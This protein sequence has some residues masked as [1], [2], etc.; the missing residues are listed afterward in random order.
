MPII[1]ATVTV[2]EAI[3][4]ARRPS[5]S[6]AAVDRGRHG[7]PEAEAED[8][9]QP[10]TSP[11]PRGRRPG[12]HPDERARCPGRA[13]RA[14]ITRRPSQRRTKPR[15]ERPDRRRAGE[16]AEGDPLDVRAAVEDPVDE[17]GAA[18]DRR[19]EAVA[20]QERDERRRGE[21]RATGT[22]CGSRKGLRVPR[23]RATPARPIATSADGAADEPAGPPGRVARDLLAAG[24]GEREEDERR[25][26]PRRHRAEPGRAAR[27]A[28]VS[29]PAEAAQARAS[30]AIAIGTFR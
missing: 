18:D 28:S 22:S 1:R 20:G 4:N 14:V 27:P 15:S 11:R 29:Q 10:A 13:R 2:A 21:G 26:R 30:A 25:A 23:S 9:E 24:Q 8:G 19:R 6:T 12:R 16:R 3:P 7:Q 5:A 17:D